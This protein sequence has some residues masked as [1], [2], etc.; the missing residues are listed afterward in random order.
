MML[1]VQ[2]PN[3]RT[4]LGE[5]VHGGRAEGTDPATAENRPWEELPRLKA[6]EGVDLDVEHDV[7]ELG[8]H[9]LIASVAWETEDGRRTFQRFLKFNVS[10]PTPSSIPV[11]LSSTQLRRQD[12]S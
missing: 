9:I 11:S 2:S 12:R 7:V 6:G 3:A 4:R 10:C 5:A 8:A 1:E